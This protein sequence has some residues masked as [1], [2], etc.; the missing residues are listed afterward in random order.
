MDHMAEY[1]KI[2]EYKNK[3]EIKGTT[4]NIS[5]LLT[6]LQCPLKNISIPNNNIDC[7]DSAEGCL[8]CTAEAYNLDI[9]VVD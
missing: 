8:K 1:K 4:F 7:L 2:K 6:S 5:E 3:T 9:E